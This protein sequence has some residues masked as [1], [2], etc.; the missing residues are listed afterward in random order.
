MDTIPK[1]TGEHPNFH[2]NLSHNYKSKP[3]YLKQKKAA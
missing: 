1:F 3:S 2:L